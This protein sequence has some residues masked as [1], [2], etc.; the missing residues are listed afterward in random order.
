VLPYIH[1]GEDVNANVHVHVDVDV[2]GD[3]DVDV[4][5]NA[6][7]SKQPAELVRVPISYTEDNHTASASP[8]GQTTQVCNTI[9]HPHT[10]IYSYHVA[11]S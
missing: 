11:F 10:Y 8:D 7:N 3:V 9:H 1:D 6:K 4:D 2:D 5:A